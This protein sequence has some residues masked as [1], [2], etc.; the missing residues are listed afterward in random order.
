[1]PVAV[2]GA[3][4]GSGLYQQRAPPPPASTAS[5]VSRAGGGGTFGNGHRK[6]IPGNNPFLFHVVVPTCGWWWRD[7]RWCEWW[8][9]EGLCRHPFPRWCGALS[10][11]WLERWCAP[12]SHLDQSEN[13]FLK[14]NNM[15]CNYMLL[16]LF[17][18]KKKWNNR[19]TGWAINQKLHFL[20][21]SINDHKSPSIQI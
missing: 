1:M 12:Q 17:I 15:H 16:F 14:K 7:L 6:T 19:L 5:S 10:S 21:T 9:C 20:L 3:G 8:A 11:H 13:S 2:P 4:H 18:C